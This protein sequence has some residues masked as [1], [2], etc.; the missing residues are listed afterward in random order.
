M[1]SAEFSYLASIGYSGSVSDKR[2]AYFND[3]IGAKTLFPVLPATGDSTA[4][5]QAA[6]DAAGPDETVKLYGTFS[7]S[8]TIVSKGNL[9]AQSA[10]INYSGAG[11]ALQLGDTV[12][13]YHRKRILTPRLNCTS[14]PAVG[15][16]WAVGTVGIKVIDVQSS[17]ILIT[18]VRNF[19][20]G[21]YLYGSD[22]GC[23]YNNFFIG[24]LDNNKKNLV[25]E[26]LSSV[27]WTNQN[28]FVGGR[29]SHNPA[30]GTDIAGCAQ[31]WMSSTYGSNNNTFIGCSF[32]TSGAPEY[33]LDIQSGYFNIFDNCRWEAQNGAV[34]RVRWGATTAYN[35]II[36]G[37]DA[38]NLVETRV[39]GSLRNS[40]ES[41][42]GNRVFTGGTGP[43][44]IAENTNSSSSPIW[45]F[46]DAGADAALDD[47]LTLYRMQFSASN[48]KAKAKTDT[49]ERIR[50]E[51]ASGRIYFGPG[52]ATA[53]SVFILGTTGTLQVGGGHLAFATDN[54]LDVGLS[55]AN[56]PRYI[57]VGTGIQSGVFATGS[58]PSA[59]T[60]GQGTMI[61]DS[62]LNKPI[63]SDGTNWRDATGTVV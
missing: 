49:I 51:G 7:T 8:S 50:L 48:L 42:Y 52:A 12:S 34:P 38:R 10:V 41:N 4:R 26:N 56:R 53:P 30:E 60:A 44:V 24:Q 39:A 47:P 16:G 6:L 21:L 31:V 43:G 57:R 3:L 61:V 19:E 20:C 25:F 55:G 35:K 58:R 2:N 18:H 45:T 40:I 59:T 54:N 29:F 32:E 36:E 22:N 27:G 14:K 17:Q 63:W 28:I 62:T 1:T 15:A 46:M 13:T 33:L 5:I 23:V 37:Y 11:V 9:D